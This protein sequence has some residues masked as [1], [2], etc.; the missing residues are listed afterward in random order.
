MAEGIFSYNEGT[1]QTSHDDL[2]SVISGVDSSL[3]DLG[4]FVSAAKANWEGDEME[5]YAAIQSSW[6][7]AAATVREILGSVQTAL[8]T[9]TESVVTMR[10]Q[11]TSALQK[12]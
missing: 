11:V 4:G 12:Q 6:D 10:S 9:T 5:A 2:G 7:S 3:N 1:A 8:G